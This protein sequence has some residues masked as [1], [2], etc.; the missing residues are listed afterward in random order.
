MTLRVVEG[1]AMRREGVVEIVRKAIEVAGREEDFRVV[2]FNVL[3]NHV[4]LI[5]EA[6]GTAALARRMQGLMVRIARRV[7]RACGRKGNLFAER[8][9]ARVLRSPREARNAIRYVLLNARHHAAE[10]GETLARGWVDPYSSAAWF[11]GWRE[12][13]RVGQPWLRRLVA[14]PAPTAAPRTWLLAEGWKR[15]GLIGYDEVPGS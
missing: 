3:G 14:R 8:Y 1:V 7:N 10:R 4:H 12:P 13:M 15:G 11:D 9:H 2:H 6:G 5:V